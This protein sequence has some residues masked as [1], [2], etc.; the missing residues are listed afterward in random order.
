MSELRRATLED[1]KFIDDL[2][3]RESDAVG[4]V[5]LIRYEQ[6]VSGARNGRLWV[7]E[8]NVDPVGFAFVTFGHGLARIQ[9]IAVRED[10]RRMERATSLVKAA[11]AEARV[12]GLR[13]LGCRV[14]DD[15][16]SNAFW[17]ALGFSAVGNVAG[18]LRRNRRITYW[19]A[20]LTQR[21]LPDLP[22]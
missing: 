10:A 16:E 12:R 8:E 4:F 19:R 13:E 20:A 18:G 21:L 15:L 3:R 1:L 11:A 9:Q 22:S 5:P 17:E 2:R 7:I 6:E 14:A